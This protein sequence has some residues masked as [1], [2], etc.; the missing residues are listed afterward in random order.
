MKSLGITFS[1]IHFIV[2]PIR[3]SSHPPEEEHITASGLSTENEP[4]EHEPYYVNDRVE[5]TT[6]LM[7]SLDLA[8]WTFCFKLFTRD[9]PR[10]PGPPYRSTTREGFCYME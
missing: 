2:T 5:L 1:R 4:Q 6:S 9:G 7:E 3:I 10:K 8:H